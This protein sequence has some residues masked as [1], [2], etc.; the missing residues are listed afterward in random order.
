MVL[1]DR[2]KA[3]VRRL[4]NA[5]G[6]DIVGYNGRSDRWRMARLL[7]RHRITVLFDV[8]ANRGTFGWD[9]RELGFRG[10]IVSFEPLSEAFSHLERMARADGN[11]QALNIGLGECDEDRLLNV[12]ANSQSS[13]F[14]PMLDAH[15][16]AAPESLYER[17]ERTAVRRLDG[18][19]DNYCGPGDAAFLK[20]DTQGFEKYVL[21]GARGKLGAVPL[22]Q[23]ECSLVPLYQGT[24]VVEDMIGYMR[25]L[26]YDPVHV[27]PTFY[28]HDS[29][30]LMQADVV[31]LRR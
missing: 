14:L 5:L 4:A 7:E 18:I 1:A 17:E 9:M 12:A 24:N 11:W 3:A 6:Y 26:G 28:H 19:F 15:K 29:G 30:H 16:R 10:R 31:F 25:G 22:V 20:I 8:G 13:S 27:L 23:L 2:L 21:E